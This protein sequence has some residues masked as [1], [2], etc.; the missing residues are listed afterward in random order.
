MNQKAT[1][2]SKIYHFKLD[3]ILGEGG[4]GTVYR[5]IDQKTGEPVAVKV[6]HANFFNDASE[7]R[8][9]S[10]SVTRFQ[11][12]DHQNV[13][14]VLQFL[15]G[16]EEPCLVMEY[17]DGPDMKWY[18]RERPWNMDERLVIIYQICNGLQYIHDQGF[19]HH[20]LKPENVLFTRKGEVKLCDYAL[21]RAKWSAIFERENKLAGSVT[22]MYIAPEII[23]KKAASPQSDMYSLGVILYLMFAGEF[24]FKADNLQALYVSHLKIKPDHPSGVNRRCPPDLGDVIMKLLSKNPKERF[25]TCD[26]VRIA[27]ANVGQSRI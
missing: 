24:P 5:G 27:L 4:T 23:D 2:R 6:F 19:V 7:I 18:I 8:D 21:R 20:D 15:H 11:K 12:F 10:K 3:R 1:N 26:Q 17:V 22:P 14:R 9:L 25:E 16:G 13:T